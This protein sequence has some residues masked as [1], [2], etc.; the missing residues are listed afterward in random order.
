MSQSQPKLSV[1]DA[2]IGAYIVA[3]TTRLEEALHQ[4]KAATETMAAATVYVR[5]YPDGTDALTA[6]NGDHEWGDD[7]PAVCCACEYAGT[8]EEFI[9]V[10]QRDRKEE[11]TVII[12]VLG[13]VAHV[14]QSP[15]DI[16]VKIID[17]DT[18]EKDGAS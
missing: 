16:A 18:P 9:Q 15:P 4:A 5:L 8:V 12:E 13:G 7:S 2:A 3:L 14:K 6:R 10:N 17:Y 11:K 1:V